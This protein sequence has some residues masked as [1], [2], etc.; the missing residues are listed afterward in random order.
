[1]MWSACRKRNLQGGTTGFCSVNWTI[2]MR[3]DGQLIA[4]FVPEIAATDRSL[5][6]YSG[7]SQSILVPLYVIHTPSS[8]KSYPRGPEE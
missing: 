6:R 7:G 1:M 5:D 2:M 4:T 3:C 8:L